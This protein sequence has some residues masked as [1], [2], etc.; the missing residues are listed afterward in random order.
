VLMRV[1]WYEDRRR[2][3]HVHLTH[4]DTPGA[5]VTVSIH[6]REIVLPKTLLRILD[7]AGLTVD[8]FRGLL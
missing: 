8:E 7:Q 4:R 6:A 1:G 3:S 2:G 5:R